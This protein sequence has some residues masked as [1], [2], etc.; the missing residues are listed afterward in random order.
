MAR[1]RKVYEWTTRPSGGGTGLYDARTIVESHGGS[2]GLTSEGAL[3]VVVL[4]C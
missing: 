1:A 2:V 4:P 3:A